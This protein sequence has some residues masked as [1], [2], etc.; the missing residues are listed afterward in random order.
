MVYNLSGVKSGKYSVNRKDC[1]LN[2]HCLQAKT[3][4]F[5]SQSQQ[6]PLIA[7]VGPTGVGKTALSLGIAKRF[8]GEIISMDSMQI[9]RYMD[10]GTAKAKGIIKKEKFDNKKV[11]KK[12]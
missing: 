12:G 7:V 3:F 4:F 8:S 1:H 6:H 10:I 9:Y 11:A 5:M 2:F